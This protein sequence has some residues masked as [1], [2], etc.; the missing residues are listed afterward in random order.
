[1]A[2]ERPPPSEARA[3]SAFQIRLGSAPRLIIPTGS[4]GSP[5]GFGGGG[6]SEGGLAGRRRV[7]KRGKN[8][9]KKEE[10]EDDQGKG[11][12]SAAFDD[13]SFIVDESGRLVAGSLCID[14]SG[15]SGDDS[16]TPRAAAGAGG[17]EAS[18][19]P[20]SLA[21]KER[22]HSSSLSSP[23][24]AT[25]AAAVT[26]RRDALPSP[27]PSSS[28]PS[29]SLRLDD[30]EV[31]DM[32]GRGVC[33]T[34]Y[35]ARHTPSGGLVA[36][37][38]INVQ[39]RQHRHQLVHELRTLQR[40]RSPYLVAFLGAFYADPAVSVALEYMD[41]GSLAGVLDRAKRVP[42]RVVAAAGRQI[43]RGLAALHG[44]HLL[45]R[46]IK[47]S[48]IVLS[49]GGAAKLTDFG[50]ST[51]LQDSI[52]CVDTF[53]GTA[54]YMSPERVLGQPYSYSSDIWSAGLLLL[55]LVLGEFPYELTGVYI[56]LMTSITEGP[57]RV[58]DDVSPHFRDFVMSCLRT[59]ADER[60]QAAA[61]VDHPFLAAAGDDGQCRAELAA[62]LG[63]AMPLSDAAAARDERPYAPPL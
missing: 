13:S 63:E 53:V 49:R 51:E 54:N 2:E 24:V 19:S 56:D 61:L 28:S 41:G 58:P 40:S 20:S 55:Q 12:G 10:E 9:R 15:L 22:K 27:S 37:K 17:E 47:P 62:W 34:V 5:G 38:V 8:E 39:E 33:G 57:P 42:E 48:N 7:E 18:S 25:A 4:A 31:L 26:P 11:E 60:P 44:A 3:P 16:I 50:I 29:S 52:A 43:F 35:K 14:R 23:P 45:H 6:G 36:L 30:L 1:M 21:E 59:A 32:L 46:D